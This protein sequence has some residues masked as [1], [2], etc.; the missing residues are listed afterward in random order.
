MVMTPGLFIPIR[1]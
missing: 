1:N